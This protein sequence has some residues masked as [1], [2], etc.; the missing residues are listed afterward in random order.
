[1][2]KFYIPIFII[3]MLAHSCKKKDDTIPQSPTN[4]SSNTQ[5][6]I[7]NGSNPII[8]G[9]YNM[10]ADDANNIYA[11]TKQ[12][13]LKSNDNGNTWNM[14]NN[15]LP[16]NT[17]VLKVDA[18][19]GIL[20]LT[21]S[22]KSIYKSIDYGNSWQHMLQSNWIE[23][24]TNDNI[25]VMILNSNEVFVAYICANSLTSAL[26]G[27]YGSSDGGQ[28]WQLMYP[29]QW[30]VIRFEKVDPTR[31]F[32]STYYEVYDVTDNGISWNLYNGTV[33]NPAF[34]GISDMVWFNNA[35]LVGKIS[36]EGLF[37]YD[38]TNLSW[39]NI[40]NHTEIYSLMNSGQKLLGSFETGINISLNGRDWI[41]YNEGLPENL[42]AGTRELTQNNQYYFCS[43]FDY[44]CSCE[45]IVRRKK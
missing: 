21:T 20:F 12:G 45:K 36:G 28:N 44:S 23:D 33:G 10:V 31:F 34:S 24:Y 35:I 32:V 41:A 11:C 16:S 39:I 1:M 17:N 13:I 4:N 3:C 26:A 40:L 19:N 37:Q 6:E 22:K 42:I 30:G 43:T 8:S 7:T 5:W 29:L 25:D 15:G 9:N 27:V 2:H 38:F 18:Y 14:V